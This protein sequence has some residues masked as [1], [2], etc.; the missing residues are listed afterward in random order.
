M[1]MKRILPALIPLSLLLIPRAYADEPKRLEKIIVT[2]S[3][4]Q[5]PSGESG[6]SMTVLDSDT[7]RMSAY[8]ALQDIIGNLGGIDIRRRGP[9]GVQSD[10]NIRGATFEQNTVLLDGVSL[11][12]PQTGHYTMD[13]PVT[14]FDTE[15]VEI[16]KGA[17][18][19]LY[20]ANAFGGVI[21]ILTAPPEGK[22]T[23]AKV[24]GGQRDYFSAG[25]SVS[26]P[27]GPA[28]NRFSIEWNRARPY[29]PNTEFDILNM[30]DSAC[31]DTP[32]GQYDFFF[33]YSRKD[34]G[35]DS[36]YSNLYPS[37][38]EYTDTRF[39]KLAG[40]IDRGNLKIE[41]KIYLRRHYDKFIL[42][43][44][45]A[46]WQ[47]NFS[48]D[49][50]YGASLGFV[51]QS[52]FMDVAYGF[53]LSEDRIFSTNMQKHDRGKT[54]L[55]MEISPRIH[56]RLHLNAGIRQDTFS[57]FDTEYSPSVNARYAVTDFFDLRA[58]AGR[59]YRIPT[60]TDLYYTDAANIG[61]SNLKAETSWTYD[62]GFDCRVG[63]V[64]GSAT[65]FNRQ[66]KDTIDWTRMATSE[67][68]RA[69]NIGSISTNGMEMSLDM[70]P[71]AFFFF[72]RKDDRLFKHF[73]PEKLFMKYVCVDEYDKHDYLSKYAFSYAKQEILGGVEYSL[74]GF[75]NAWVLN[76]K[77]RVGSDSAPVVVGAKFTKNV[78]KK[79]K[80]N[81]EIFL[82]FT[83]L[84]DADYAEQSGIPMPGRWLKSGARLE[85]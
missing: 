25:T 47:T 46:G 61:N 6:R 62:A 42:S 18:S 71:K 30:S 58:S 1:R 82:E 7:I 28:N 2:P 41:P 64:K 53:E 29:I 31:V 52:Q 26:H 8:D 80:L 20:G 56:E 85:F 74:F 60:F 9:E 67:A 51:T 73:S 40:T 76:Y 79:D 43:K 66:S 55:Y 13:L 17:A 49:Y 63:P 5:N 54:G 57:R 36:F 24:I 21:N 77:K 33:G 59:A 68:W 16:L 70:D 22:K 69:S 83:N 38:A 72:L 45:R 65:Y 39:F 15:R 44:D 34:F 12:D 23:V 4:I 35:A 50:T 84:F 10:V 27:A 37:E 78:I 11:N 14:S 32:I 19:S 48:T 81:F 75:T 3:R